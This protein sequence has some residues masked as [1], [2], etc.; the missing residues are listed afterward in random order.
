MRLIGIYAVSETSTQ[1]EVVKMQLQSRGSEKETQNALF[2]GR[3][4]SLC[5]VESVFACLG[6]VGGGQ[7]IQI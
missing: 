2:Q 3:H 4:A 5:T 7:K 6:R 1:H